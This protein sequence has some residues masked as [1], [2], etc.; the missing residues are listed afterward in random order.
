MLNIKNQE[1]YLFITYDDVIKTFKPYILEILRNDEYREGYSEVIDYSKIDG[2]SFNELFMLSVS[3]TDK[4]IFRSLTTFPFDYDATYYDLLYNQN[5][6]II[7]KAALLSMGRSIKILLSQNYVKRIYIYTEEFNQNIFDDLVK[8]Y[9]GESRI[10]YV[11]GNLEDVLDKIT[12]NITF[13][14]LNDITLINTLIKKNRIANSNVIVGSFGYNY[15]FSEDG[16]PVLKFDNLEEIAQKLNF[17]I[18]VFNPDPMIQ[19]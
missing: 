9:S 2:K 5:P 19:T 18:G 13:Y 10:D 14:A 4:N 3:M 6:D 7:E 17:R 16:V 8:E 15:K 11:S 12:D 1:E